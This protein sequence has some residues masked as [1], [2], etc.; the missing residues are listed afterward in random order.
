MI[1]IKMFSVV[2]FIILKIRNN[3]FF[4]IGILIY[5]GY[6]VLIYEVVYSY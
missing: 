1:C 5:Y 2:L 4:M 6:G 3:Y